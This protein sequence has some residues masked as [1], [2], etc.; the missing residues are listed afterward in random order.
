MKLFVQ[1][2]CLCIFCTSAFAAESQE[3]FQVMSHSELLQQKK[4]FYKTIWDKT[5]KNCDISAGNSIEKGVYE[6]QKKHHRYRMS[7]K[8]YCG[9]V[10]EAVNG[11]PIAQ[12]VLGLDEYRRVRNKAL[13]CIEFSERYCR[14]ML[15]AISW[16]RGECNE[17]GC[18]L[19]DK[20]GIDGR[21]IPSDFESMEKYIVSKI[22]Q[23]LK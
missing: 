4:D 19:W 9:I 8:T 6:K 20:S 2:I 22:V 21:E 18:A 5:S 16:R 3:C 11:S 13:C 10:K 23:Y 1:C 7:E 12:Y 17:S 14:L 15:W